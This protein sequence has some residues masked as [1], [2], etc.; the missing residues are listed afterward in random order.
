MIPGYPERQLFLA[1]ALSCPASLASFASVWLQ[2]RC[3]AI[4]DDGLQTPHI[5]AGFH[6]RGDCVQDRLQV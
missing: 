3:R 1:L 6:V 5:Q 2:G 4:P